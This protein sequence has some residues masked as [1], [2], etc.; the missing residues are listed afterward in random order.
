MQGEELKQSPV[1]FL[2]Y[3]SVWTSEKLMFLECMSKNI[4][5]KETE[6]LEDYSDP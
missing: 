3:D 6:H 2:N 1:V 5:E 4:E